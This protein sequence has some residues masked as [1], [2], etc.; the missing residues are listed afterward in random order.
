M[1]RPAYQSYGTLYRTRAVTVAAR[2]L[3]TESQDDSHAEPRVH[4]ANP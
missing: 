3:T 2:T 4:R 1:E